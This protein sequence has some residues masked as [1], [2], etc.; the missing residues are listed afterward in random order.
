MKNFLTEEQ[1]LLLKFDNTNVISS[2]DD[3]GS[4]KYESDIDKIQERMIEDL[5]HPN[6]LVGMFT[7]GKI[8]KIL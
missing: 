1:K 2:G 3:L 6:G 8:S 5:W 7:L 4:Q